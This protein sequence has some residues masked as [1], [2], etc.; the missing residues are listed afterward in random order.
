M[1][2]AISTS[3][4]GLFLSGLGATTEPDAVL[5]MVHATTSPSGLNVYSAWRIPVFRTDV[6]AFKVGQ[7]VFPHSSVPPAFWPE[8]WP[9]AKVYGSSP[10]S[11]YAL[12][13]RKP[14]T[15]TEA[16]RALDLTGKQ[17]WLY[18]LYHRHGMRDIFYCPVGRLMIAFWSGKPLRLTWERRASLFQLALYSAF[19]LDELVVAK[20]F[21]GK[22]PPL[23][24]RERTILRLAS[25]G[26]RALAI[27]DS[28]GISDETVRHHLKRVTK[29]LGAK[30]PMHAACQALR[31]H[32][33]S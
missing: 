12:L 17:T 26:M 16:M 8:Y 28:L 15:M 30:S 27:A 22:A 23:S 19:R 10:M 4:L 29:K 6:E 14:I 2:L 18:D 9:L 21:D 24:A 32:L 31:L 3:H 25:R 13:Q 33:I 5:D 7:N 20:K 1:A 11:I